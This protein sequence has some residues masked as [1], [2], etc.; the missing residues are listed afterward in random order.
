MLYQN[1]TCFDMFFRNGVLGILINFYF[2]FLMDVIILEKSFVIGTM[3]GRMALLFLF[4][5]AAAWACDARE[6]A[7]RD[8]LSSNTANS[9]T[10]ENFFTNFFIQF[11]C[12]LPFFNRV[13][14]CIVDEI[15]N[16]SFL[17]Y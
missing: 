15:F 3:E 13:D 12:F 11:L 7:K 1:G 10:F 5:L 6:L 14:A 9:G 16:P 4:V 8:Q 2:F 17:V